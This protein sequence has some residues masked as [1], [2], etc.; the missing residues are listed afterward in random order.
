MSCSQ[1]HDL[2]P[3]PS[4]DKVLPS[5]LQKA[6]VSIMSQ[7]ECKKSYGPVSPRMLCAGVLSGERDACRV[8]FHLTQSPAF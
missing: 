3:T 2:A 1:L 7:T 8:S 5:V 6:E 4:A